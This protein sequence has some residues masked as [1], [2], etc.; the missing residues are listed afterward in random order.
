LLLLL[1]Y[2]QINKILEAMLR[3]YMNRTN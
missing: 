2:I 3:N 1:L